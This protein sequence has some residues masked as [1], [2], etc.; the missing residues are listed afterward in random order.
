MRRRFWAEAAVA[1]ANALL[2]LMT[3]LDRDWIEPT[4]GVHP[5]GGNGSLERL[6][7]AG[8]LAATTTFGLLARAERAQPARAG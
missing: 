4:F 7:V 1:V 6:I 8:L 3:L 5:D 2:L